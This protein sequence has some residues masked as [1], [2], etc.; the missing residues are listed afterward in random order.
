MAYGSQRNATQSRASTHDSSSIHELV[1][2]PQEAQVVFTQQ[3]YS[4][5]LA[6]MINDLRKVQL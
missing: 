6:V 5:S 2:Q 4:I 3:P 1:Q